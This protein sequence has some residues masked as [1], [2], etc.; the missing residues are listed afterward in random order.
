M[1]L[2][3]DGRMGQDSAIECVNE[4]DVS[5]GVYTS[6]TRAEPNNYGAR[7]SDIVRSFPLETSPLM[8]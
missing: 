7:R 6:M 8:F 2:S 1:A 3:E 5:V 4:N